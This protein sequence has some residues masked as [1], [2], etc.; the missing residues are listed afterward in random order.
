MKNKI[1]S[2]ACIALILTL[3]LV[4]PVAALSDTAYQGYIY[5]SY[6]KSNPAPIGYEPEKMV[7]KNVL[8]LDNIGRLYD[9]D[10]DEE[11]LL[12]VLDSDLSSIYVLDIDMNLQSIIKIYDVNNLINPKK[13]DESSSDENKPEEVAPADNDENTA[14]E[15]TTDDAL[16][17]ETKLVDFSKANGIYIH[18]K[19]E[20]KLIYINQAGV[21]NIK[22]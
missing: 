8:G 5:D 15:E 19:G 17:D 4:T 20:E 11:G 2:I 22:S 12:Y 13:E 14:T 3:M 1:L 6:D 21:K 16:M 7:N 10:F 18:G 9:M